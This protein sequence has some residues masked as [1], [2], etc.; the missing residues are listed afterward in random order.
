MSDAQT[1]YLGWEHFS[2]HDGCAKPTWDVAIRTEDGYRRGPGAGLAEHSCPNEDCGHNGKVE[3]FTVRIVCRSCGAAHL[4]DGEEPARAWRSTRS[5]G[6]G[7]PPVKRAGL[8]L[9]PDAPLDDWG[10]DPQPWEYLVTR[11]GV[12]RV[13]EDDVVGI[14][15]QGSGPRGALRW[16]AGAVPT[17]KGPYGNLARLRWAHSSRDHK[18]TAAAAKWIAAQLAAEGG[19]QR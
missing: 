19:E 14:L 7:Q 11:P 9:W 10:R 2:H 13:T 3:R 8:L 4:V 6:Y 12:T 5:I 18:T 15:G 17:S 1:T 16:W